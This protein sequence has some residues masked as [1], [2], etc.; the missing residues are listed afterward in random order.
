MC[1]SV[2]QW[3]VYLIYEGFRSSSSSFLEKLQRKLWKHSE[4]WYNWY[5]LIKNTINSGWVHFVSGRDGC[6]ASREK[7]EEDN[8]VISKVACN[9]RFPQLAEI[10]LFWATTCVRAL[11]VGSTNLVLTTQTSRTPQEAGHGLSNLRQGCVGIWILGLKAYSHGKE[12]CQASLGGFISY[13]TRS[14][15]FIQNSKLHL[16]YLNPR[17]WWQ[18]PSLQQLSQCYRY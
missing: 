8:G 10:W 6:G 13:G 1:Q 9:V 12:A 2:I 16:W 17:Q 11:P 4:L 3:T 14:K 18:P 7:K 15:L 5:L